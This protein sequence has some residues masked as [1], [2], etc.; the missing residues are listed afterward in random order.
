MLR[1]K[2]LSPVEL[3]RTVLD[4]IERLN[5]EVN[6]VCTL[7]A[8]AALAD[9]KR[10]EDAIMRGEARGALHGVPVTIKDLVLM[11]GVRSMF[12]SKI[13]EHRVPDQEPPF[14]RR[15]REAGAIILA[16]TTTPEFGWKAL[17]DSPLTGISRNPWNTKMTPGGSSS[18]AAA[19]AAFGF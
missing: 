13:F 3:V 5:P 10:A 9:A 1:T 2:A 15:I 14:L 11:K 6:A 7:L 4:R 12:G 17:G 8:D 18:G 19:A 16:R